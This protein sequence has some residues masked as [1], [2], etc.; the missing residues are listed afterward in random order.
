MAI[1]DSIAR[2]VN[3]ASCIPSN[4]DRSAHV[5]ALP[6]LLAYGLVVSPTTGLGGLPCLWRWAFG[7]DCPGCGLSRAAAFLVRGEFVDAVVANW[8]IVPVALAAGY[9]FFRSSPI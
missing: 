7:V 1:G 2:L 6:G 3:M 9:C 4:V 8:L 5:L